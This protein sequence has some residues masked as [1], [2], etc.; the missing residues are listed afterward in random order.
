MCSSKIPVTSSQYCLYIPKETSQMLVSMGNKQ[1]LHIKKNKKLE[2]NGA[3]VTPGVN[4]LI[5]L[6]K[7]TFSLSLKVES[8]TE[9]SRVNIVFV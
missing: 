1:S 4:S 6:C 9:I 8:A 7:K 5:S 3:N 2:T